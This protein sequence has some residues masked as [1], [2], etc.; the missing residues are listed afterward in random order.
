M[1]CSSVNLVT[2]CYINQI[3]LD[4]PPS[5][6]IKLLGS[7]STSDPLTLRQFEVFTGCFI[8]IP[9]DLLMEETP[10]G[11]LVIQ[12]KRLEHQHDTNRPLNEVTI[13]LPSVLVE[14]KPFEITLTMGDL[15]EFG[16]LVPMA[17]GF[18]NQTGATQKILISLIDIEGF[19]VS[20]DVKKGFEVK[21]A[22]TRNF[23]FNLL[24]L[25]VGRKKLPGVQ[26]VCQTMDNKIIWDSSGTR[27]ITVI[28]KKN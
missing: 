3:R 6:Y 5:L 17:L 27:F 14:S 22:E 18:R 15:T 13:P 20:G 16:E 2:E 10:I 1:P 28:P 4:P 11:N 9:T 21:N 12:W 23:E 24:P 8:I 26:L 19:L 7:L 25:G